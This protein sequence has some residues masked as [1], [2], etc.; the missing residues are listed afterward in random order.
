MRGPGI[1]P[2]SVLDGPVGNIDVA[3]TI[4]ELTGAAMP[5]DLA[6]VLDGVSLMPELTVGADPSDRAI[7]IEGRDNVSRARGGFAVRS[8]VGVRTDRYAYVENRRASAPSK[9][10][11]AAL[12][13]GLGRTTDVE[14]YDLLRDPHELKNVERD[15]RY[16]RV[17]SVLA[18]L[19]DRLDQCNGPGC[20]VT[21]SVPAP[22]ARPGG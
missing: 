20:V 18:A 4:L 19:A 11:G 7:L 10:A 14:L 5:A 2:G 15:P 6:R 16:R 21:E 9:A 22:S 1:A 17:R 12:E 8:Y 13:I 3:P